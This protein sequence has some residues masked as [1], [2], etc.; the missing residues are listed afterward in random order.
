MGNYS[1]LIGAIIGGIVGLGVSKGFL[2]ADLASPENVAALTTVTAAFFTYV[3]P[4]NKS[5]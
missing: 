3:F 5:A 1:K 2:P 4:A